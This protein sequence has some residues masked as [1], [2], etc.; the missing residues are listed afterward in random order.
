MK[1]FFSFSEE[2]AV[3]VADYGHSRNHVEH[4]ILSPVPGLSYQDS[5]LT[6]GI[7]SIIETNLVI[8]KPRNPQQNQ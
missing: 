3:D 7:L 5:S 2:T 4:Q 6:L 8:I 1:K